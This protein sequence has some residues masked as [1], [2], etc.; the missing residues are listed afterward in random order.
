MPGGPQGACEVRG[1]QPGVT[2]RLSPGILAAS[3]RPGAPPSGTCWPV[4]SGAVLREGPGITAVLAASAGSTRRQEMDLSPVRWTGRRGWLLR[5]L[6]GP[7]AAGM[8]PYCGRGWRLVPENGGSGAPEPGGTPGNTLEAALRSG[9]VTTTSNPQ[10]A[11]G[12]CRERMYRGEGGFRPQV[13]HVVRL[14]AWARGAV[15]PPHRTGPSWWLILV[16][17]QG[18]STALWSAQGSKAECLVLCVQETVPE[19]KEQMAGDHQ[20]DVSAAP[21]MGEGVAGRGRSEA[22]GLFPAL[23]IGP[24]LAKT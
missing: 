3:G 16:H 5:L 12:P 22:F 1:P 2:D 9:A 14:S 4:L 10:R 11:A 7:G 20:G 15:W 18:V 13:P 23:T 8:D 24:G 19:D 17:P 6:A 21:A